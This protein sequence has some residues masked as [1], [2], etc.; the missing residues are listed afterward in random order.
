MFFDF[1]VE[2]PDAPGLLVRK[3]EEAITLLNTNTNA[4][5]IRSNSTPI[6]SVQ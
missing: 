2:V 5:T 4:L 1:Q 3:K 6:R